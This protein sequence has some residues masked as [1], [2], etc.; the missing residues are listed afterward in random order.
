VGY[1]NEMNMVGHKAPRKNIRLKS[2]ELFFYELQ[3]L[4]PVVVAMK[5]VHR[6]NTTLGNMMRIIYGNNS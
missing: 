5:D 1:R 2:L 6:S 4:I 3:I